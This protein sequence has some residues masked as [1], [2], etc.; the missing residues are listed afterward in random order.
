MIAINIFI[1]LLLALILGCWW[2]IL[3]KIGYSKL[4]LIPCII[5]L[6]AIIML[7]VLAFKKWPLEKN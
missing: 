6:F 3:D 4:W 7:W 2:L 1:I 5:P